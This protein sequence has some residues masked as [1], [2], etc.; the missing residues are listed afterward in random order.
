MLERPISLTY[1]HRILFARQVFQPTD[2]TLAQLLKDGARAPKVLVFV[3][4]HV[5][6]A[7]PE[8]PAELRAYADARPD[9]LQL[10]AGPV[11]IPGG[12]PCKNDFSLV[13]SCWQAMNDAGMD[14]HSYVFVIG[15]G[16]VLDL[17]CFAAS[18]A[19]RG[20]RH[21]RF[22][23]TTLSQGDGGV[24][25]KN[26]VN[27]F[28]KKNWVGS[29]AVPYA[30]VNDFAFLDSLPSREKRCGII[31]G[32]KVALIRDAA[33]YHEIERMAP[34]LAA[35]KAPALERLIR[36]SAELHVEHI[37]TSGD[38]FEL[39]SARPLDFG[40]WAAHK[41]EQVSR[42]RIAHG[43]AVAIGMAID[44]L[45][46]V[47]AG[48]LD[49]PTA[50]RIIALVEAIGFT[51]YAPELDQPEIMLAGLE[52]FREHLGG[53]LTVTLVPEIGQKLEVHEMQS[54][55]ILAAVAELRDR[56]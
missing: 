47:H 44:L 53:E 25:V 30:V 14:R 54:D 13:Q 49:R 2:E 28:G 17:V 23:T 7:K 34:D 26:G 43:E 37:A 5:L 22:P 31:E 9:V 29:F 42:F 3:D 56:A 4:S 21:I 6:A 50:E 38:P 18:T 10:A 45:Y 36:R 32:I 11:V 35:L 40:H 1:A 15:G 39:G 46:S 8:L 51:T 52:E 24:G 48:L 20:I 55:W 16:A 19:H 33:F 41:L 12:E 27:F